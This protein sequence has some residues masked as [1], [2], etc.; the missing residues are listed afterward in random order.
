MAADLQGTVKD[1]AVR[2]VPNASITARNPGTNVSYM[3]SN[4]EVSIACQLDG[5]YEITVEAQ[6]FKRSVLSKV[7]LTMG[8][9]ASVDVALEPGQITES[10]TISDATADIVELKDQSQPR[11]ISNELIISN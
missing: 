3:T 11:S 4:E 9:T 8:Q 5:D 6:N 2:C 7:N 10:V 1:S